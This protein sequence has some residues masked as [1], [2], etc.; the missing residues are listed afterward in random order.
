VHLFGQKWL[1]RAILDFFPA[2]YCGGVIPAKKVFQRRANRTR[3][4]K[5]V[6]L[7][8]NIV[9]NDTARLEKN[10]GNIFFQRAEQGLNN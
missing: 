7:D 4:G 6:R 9:K 10:I 8:L 3:A 1:D 2:I 5:S